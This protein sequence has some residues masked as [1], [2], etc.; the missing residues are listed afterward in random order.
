MII[1]AV[2]LCTGMLTACGGGEKKDVVAN[3]AGVP[4]TRTAVS[5]WM[6][7]MA[8]GDYYELSH[9]HTIP[10]E[11]VS[12]P[13]NYP[14]CVSQ[15]EAVAAKVPGKARKHTSV[16]LLDKC[17]KLYEAVKTQATAY[18]VRAQ[19]AA[20]NAREL[21]I[22]VTKPEILQFFKEVEARKFP[23]G[24]PEVRQYLATR[25]LSLSD[26]YFVLKQDL[27]AERTLKKLEGAGGKVGAQALA[28][29]NQ[30]GERL[31]VKITCRPGYVVEH[32]KEYKGGPTYPNSPPASIMMEQIAEVATGK[33]VNTPAC[34]KN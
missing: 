3:V 13:P 5:H 6:G 2:L 27:L 22:T 25:R 17:H 19:W 30:A 33:C 1:V 18:L 23:G 14:H 12:D 9:K 20:D 16:E 8:G 10:A 31:N 15:L 26:L 24:A 4:I 7:T 32:C 34:G 29:Y 11:I 28:R 21:G